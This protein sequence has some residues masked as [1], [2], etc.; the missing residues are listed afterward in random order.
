MGRKSTTKSRKAK[1][2]KV[3]KWTKAI[4][5]KLKH[6]D[7][8]E[9]TMDD[10]AI[11]MKKSKST[12]YEYFKT[13]EEVFEYITQIRIDYLYDYKSEI[14]SEIIQLDYQYEVLTTILSKGAQDISAFY[15]KQLQ[16]HYPTAWKIIDDFLLDLLEDL[17][18]FYKNGIESKLFKPISIDLMIKL[19]QYFILQL[20]TDDTFFSNSKETLETIIKDYMLL[21][22]EGLM[23]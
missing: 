13:K 2:K 8:G 15:L 9:L 20:I 22:F 16:L 6:T 21:K 1:T 23:K 19:D 3:E 5:P 11:L 18:R 10:L 12:I 14:T 4:L 7:L 17:K